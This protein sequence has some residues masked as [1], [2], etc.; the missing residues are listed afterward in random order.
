MKLTLISTSSGFNGVDR[1]AELDNLRARALI[2][3]KYN[4]LIEK[5]AHAI[6]EGTKDQADAI[7]QKRLAY[8][9]E[10]KKNGKSLPLK[11]GGT[12][13]L[14]L[15][16]VLKKGSDSPDYQKPSDLKKRNDGSLEVN[17]KFAREVTSHLSPDLAKRLG[18]LRPEY[19]KFVIREVK[20][21]L[22]DMRETVSDTSIMERRKFSYESDKKNL[23]NFREKV[24]ERKEAGTVSPRDL[25]ILKNQTWRVNMAR[26]D[27]KK[28]QDK[29][30]LA[31]DRMAKLKTPEGRKEVF[32]DLV[33]L[34][35]KR[36]ASRRD[37]QRLNARHRLRI[38]TT[39]K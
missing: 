26:N 6:L 35:I 28:S 39:R 1:R 16:E 9:A 36:A 2:L 29:Y 22:N 24:K 3:G 12:K 18:G 7:K 33:E 25:E 19:Q 4:D 15:D 20:N 11:V 38:N 5:E 8:L 30:D 23:D 34:N 32:S 17:N 27:L 14:S 21:E 37:S 10:L 13:R 31:K